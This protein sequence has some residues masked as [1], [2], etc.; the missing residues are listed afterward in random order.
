MFTWKIVYGTGKDKKEVPCKNIL[1]MCQNLAS[2]ARN[3]KADRFVVSRIKPAKE[4]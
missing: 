3:A 2:L 1:F 4:D